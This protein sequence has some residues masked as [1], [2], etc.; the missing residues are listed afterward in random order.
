M[1]AEFTRCSFNHTELQERLAKGLQSRCAAC[2]YV[3]ERWGLYGY[4][5]L[6]QS[7]DEQ[8]FCSLK[9]RNKH[10][11][12]RRKTRTGKTRHG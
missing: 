4:H 12:V 8:L 10:Y 3:N 2:G 5:F 11:G 6:G 9:C 1:G 7:R